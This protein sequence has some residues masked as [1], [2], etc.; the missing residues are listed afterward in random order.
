MTVREIIRMGHPALRE[1]AEP[2][3]IESIGSPAFDQLVE[4]LIDTLAASG[5][6]GL[7]APQ[8]NER[9]QVALVHIPGG[10]HRYGDLETVPP[11]IYVN[12][13]I[14]VLDDSRQ[15][16][17]EGC[18]S[19]PGLR[20]F[21]VRPQRIA[22]DYFDREGKPKHTEVTGFT[23]T[24]FQHEFDHLQAK[25]YI[26]HIEDSRL[27]VFEDQFL[28]HDLDERTQS[29]QEEVTRGIL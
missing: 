3:P 6:I 8:I 23:A 29:L 27:L 9:V 25:L 4:D 2:Y 11:T 15:G 21:V 26:D 22:I 24:V 10:P 1:V 20:G 18:L 28:E 12:P 13:V 19:V 17:W 5:G 7:A 14:Q 16:Y